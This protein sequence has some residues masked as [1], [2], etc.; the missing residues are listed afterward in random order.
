[1][2][3]QSDAIIRSGRDAGKDLSGDTGEEECCGH[4]RVRRVRIARNII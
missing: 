2:N 4:R 1:M 3:G